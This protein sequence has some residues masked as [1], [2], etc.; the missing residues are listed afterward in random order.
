MLCMKYEEIFST[1]QYKSLWCPWQC[2]EGYEHEDAI[3][4]RVQHPFAGVD[5]ALYVIVR[6]PGKVIVCVVGSRGGNI[7]A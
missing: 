2:C 4:N 5:V 6:I 1:K 3:V 7:L